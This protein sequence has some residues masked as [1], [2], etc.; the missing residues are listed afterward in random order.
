MSPLCGR[1]ALGLHVVYVVAMVKAKQAKEDEGPRSSHLL[2]VNL[3]DA[4]LC[5]PSPYTSTHTLL[6]HLHH[7]LDD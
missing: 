4:S 1:D 2:H 7:T 6:N 3:F 5:L